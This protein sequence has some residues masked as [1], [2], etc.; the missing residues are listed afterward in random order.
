MGFF[1]P[2][3]PHAA[4]CQCQRQACRS[5]RAARLYRSGPLTGAQ[6][7]RLAAVTERETR[8]IEARTERR[9][10]GLT[11]TGARAKNTGGGSYMTPGLFRRDM[12]RGRKIVRTKGKMR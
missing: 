1:V 5:A 4:G 3:G 8:V 6:Q 11:K 10:T 2:K 9:R 7:L 12:R